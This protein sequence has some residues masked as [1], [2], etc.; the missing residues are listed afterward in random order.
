[1]AVALHDPR[2]AAATARRAAAVGAACALTAAAGVGLALKA[3][4]YGLPLPILSVAIAVP[5]WLALT[6][7]RGLAL[8]IALCY[9]CLLDGV[10]KLRS[11]GQAATLGR[12][13]V[14]YAVIAGMAVRSRGPFRLPALAGWAVAWTLVILVQLANPA[15]HSVLHSVAS[16][17][18][19]LEFVPLFF[20]GYTALRSRAS[21]QGFF[22]VL[23]AVAAINGVVGAYQSTLSPDQ[24][25]RWGPGYANLLTGDAGRTFAGP[26]NK[27]R[28]RP[29]GLGSDMGF[30]G[31][32]GLTALPGGIALLLTYR[33]RPWRLALVA[34]GI[35]GALV[36]VL[37][38]ESRSAIVMG[39]VAMLAML[40][41]MAVGR[42]VR[43][44]M[45]A[46]CVA[47]VV[48]A[49]A[50]SAVSSYSSGAFYR[51][52]SIAPTRAVS[53]IDQSRSGTWATTPKYIA[54]IPLGAGIGSVGPAADKAGGQSTTLWNAESQFNFLI[55][56]A[57]VPG[58]LVFLAF[59]V[60][61]CGAILRGLRR[62]RDPRTVILM[63][64]LAAP[65]FAYASGWFFG[66]NTTST[67]NA[68]YLWLAAGVVSWW[69]ASGPR[70]D[71]TSHA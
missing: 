2:A 35:V 8:A 33:R 22:A 11:G 13:V 31:V 68:P 61:L 41:L 5:A 54:E 18:Q 45:I 53:T 29:P 34:V 16:L 36:G 69:L 49:I 39:V 21:L 12:D 24:L 48:I 27:P 43:R 42:E 63:S 64:A 44:S 58:L 3:P 71:R 55:V 50:V 25:A 37:T 56:E 20:V 14:M 38:S 32:L 40:G 10:V 70:A 59:Q 1:M 7:R 26:D 51:Y 9:L 57:G 66:V 4:Y 60:A 17:R 15:D 65:L 23:L 30:A 6:A 62:V 67:P 47:G 28:V 52:S 19:H 46:L